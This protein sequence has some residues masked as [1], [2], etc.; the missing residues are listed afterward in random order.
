MIKEA[1]MHVG[2]ALGLSL[3]LTLSGCASFT[4]D[5]VAPVSMPSMASYT[6]KPNVYVDFDFYQGEPQQASAVE[7]PGARDSLRP[8][9]QKTLNDSG[10]FG[11]ITL[12]EFQKQPGDYTLRLKVYNHGANGG[13]LV[14]A[15]I[16]GF[17]FGVIPAMATDQYTM[18][19]EALDQQGASLHNISNHDEVNTWIGL[20]FI[21]L[22]VK[23]PTAA[24]NDTFTRQVNALLKQ[25]VESQQLKYSA[26]E[27]R[28]P[29]A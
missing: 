11:R 5:Q 19:L 22:M 14:M 12:D 18:T 16:S 26:L 15:A 25:M 6:N 24:V 9:L 7:M 4:S 3:A 10:L 21:P 2:K 27:L 13:Q 23:T 20:I 28:T 17:S 1:V 29:R 8:A